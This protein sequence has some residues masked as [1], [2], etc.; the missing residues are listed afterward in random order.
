M[1]T[2]DAVAK[3]KERD[4]SMF[5]DAHYDWPQSVQMAYLPSAVWTWAVCEM[6][7]PPIVLYNDI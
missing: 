2:M 3:A 6:A 4:P 5:E 7:E 1:A